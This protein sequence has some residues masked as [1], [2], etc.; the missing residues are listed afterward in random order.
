MKYCKI[1]ANSKMEKEIMLEHCKEKKKKNASRKKALLS[2]HIL[3][4]FNGKMF[5]KYIIHMMS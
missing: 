2:F 3:N 1:H 5:V 4:A